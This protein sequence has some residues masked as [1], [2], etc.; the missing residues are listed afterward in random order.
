MSTPSKFTC[1]TLIVLGCC[2]SPAS[3]WA[4]SVPSSASSITTPSVAMSEAD[5]HAMHG[6]HH[7]KSSAAEH[8]SVPAMP[9]MSMPAASH[10]EPHA[11]QHGAEP[12]AKHEQHA[13]HATRAMSMAPMQGG[14]APV[15]ARDPDY[16]DGIT[17]TPEH[18]LHMHGA[19]RYTM[20]QIDR[21]EYFDAR[22]ER[23]TALEAQAWY[24][25]D[26]DKLMLQLEGEFAHGRT[27]N[28]RSEVAWSHAVSAFWDTQ[29]GIR[30]DSGMGPA[31]NWA[32][33]GVQGLAPYWL[34]VQASAYLGPGGRTAARVELEYELLFTQRLILTPKFEVNAY[35]KD[36][37]ARG[38]GSGVS[39]A[40]FGLRLRYEIRRRFAPY[41]GVAWS[42]RFGATADF[43]R[44][45]GEATSDWQLV[46]GIR[47]WF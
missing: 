16:S 28:L 43:A 41:L 14:N 19:S 9:P 32:A 36:D 47:A 38:L 12:S 20:L 33:F 22:N 7:A 37:P 29:L 23:G 35:G 6:M 42:H 13:K 21:L 39:D 18:G 45:R 2:A 1:L 34:E 27:E 44:R 40:E 5:M 4:Q 10:A 3:V 24:G 46:A 8:A 25:G 17:F 31:R 26:I 11:M 15:D 30:H